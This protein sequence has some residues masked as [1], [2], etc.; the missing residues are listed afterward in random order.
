MSRRSSVGTLWQIGLGIILAGCAAGTP[1]RIA[2][3]TP[4]STAS[5]APTPILTPPIQNIWEVEPFA[6]L[7]SGTYFIDPDLDPSTPVRVVYEVPFEGWSMWIGAVKFVDGG[8]TCS[9]SGCRGHPSHV[10][11]SITTVTNL[12]RHGCRDHSW[13]DPPVGPTVEDLATALAG[14]APFRVTSRPKDVTIEL[15]RGDRH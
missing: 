11:V 6:R 3:L 1:T 12:V 5:S 8:T 9:S 2:T 13:A 7:E 14:L 10:G 4:I 15:G